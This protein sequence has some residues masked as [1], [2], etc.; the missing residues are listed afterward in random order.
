MKR[1]LLGILVLLFVFSAHAQTAIFVKSDTITSGNWRGAY[2]ADGA[3][4]ALQSYAMPPYAG[5]VL[6]S[7]S[8]WTW[9][10][11]ANDSRALNEDA[12]CW[13]SPSSFSIYL[14]TNDNLTHQIALYAIDYDKQGRSETFTLTNPTTNAIL[15]TRT[16]SNFSQGIWEVWN[17]T[18]DVNVTVKQVA[19]PNAVLSGV[20]FSTVA[21]P[22][23][24][25]T[26]PAPK[27]TLFWAPV[28]GATSYNILRGTVSGG[29]YTQQANVT[30][31]SYLDT[32]IV[33]GQ[34]YYYV[35][36][37]VVGSTTSG[38]SVQMTAVVPMN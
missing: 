21:T 16:I 6:N 30:T 5:D 33:A 26:C 36:D 34:T 15:D 13:Y 28:T 8:T 1:Y 35:T 19:G 20:F 25:I 24:P 9:A 12:T 2:G 31:T 4:V 23:T 18:G 32:T 29:P 10:N 37:S 11:P 22:P 14:S 38:Y 17:I 27:L 7:D 3:L